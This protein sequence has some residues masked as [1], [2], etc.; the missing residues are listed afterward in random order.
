MAS[1]TYISKRQSNFAISR[2]FNF[3]ETSLTAK[4]REKTREDFRIY[5]M[6]LD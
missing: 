1:F 6:P 4:C 3:H 5:S 2:G